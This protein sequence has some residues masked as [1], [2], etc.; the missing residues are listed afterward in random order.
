[1]CDKKF[2]YFMSESYV[3]QL[4]APLRLGSKIGRSS[5]IQCQIYI[6][7]EIERNLFPFFFGMTRYCQGKDDQVHGHILLNLAKVAEI[8]QNMPG[9]IDK[10]EL[11]A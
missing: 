4:K 9:Q 6:F 10:L 11:Y 3:L 1:M 7:L 2:T 5:Q 8:G